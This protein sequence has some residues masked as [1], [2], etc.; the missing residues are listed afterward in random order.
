MVAAVFSVTRHTRKGRALSHVLGAVGVG[1][2]VCFFNK[3]VMVTGLTAPIPL[4][5]SAATPTLVTLLFATAI[6]LSREDG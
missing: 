2:G 1:F 3:L 5:L 6:L 4:W